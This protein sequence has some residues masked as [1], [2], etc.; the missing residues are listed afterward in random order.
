M[1]T[2]IKNGHVIDINLKINEI[3]DIYINDG[4]VE[5]IGK[6]NFDKSDNTD[7]SGAEVID[8]K[9]MYVVPG[10]IDAHCHLRDPGFE[11]KE[12]IESG[13]RSA[14]KGGFTSVA[15][16]PNTNP[17]IDN[18]SVVSYVKN[19]SEKE[20][21]VN[22]FPIGAISKGCKGEELAEIG[23]LKFA[24]AVAISD[25]GKPVN[26]AGLMK[27]ALM[28]SSMFDIRVISH[29]EELSLAEDGVMNEGYNSTILGLKG[30]PAAAEETMIA[31]DLILS[32]Y[33]SVP[34]HIA[35]VS[36][37]LGI[38]LIR[39]AKK[40]GV[41]V[42]CE[43]C[44][45]YFSLTD[46]ACLEFN[47]LAKVNPP[48]RRDSDVE[49]VIEGLS[50]GTIDIIATDHAPHHND[51]KKIEFGYAAN[52]MV[53]FETALSLTL[54][55]LYFTGKLSMEQII[56]KMTVNPAKI[57]NIPK[58]DIAVGKPC[59][60]TIFNPDEEYEIN[61]AEFESKGKNSPFDGY[62]VKGRVKYTIVNGNIVV[63]DGVVM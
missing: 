15:C 56:E 48:L 49:A 61:I 11:Y 21:Y 18:E 38:D 45:H 43:T 63:R 60:I 31:R 55:N 39:N 13:T 35:H 25:D 5:A 3:T 34:V 57:L 4:I 24:G 40:R 37:K 54:T 8:A 42:T 23:E 53:G 22:V 10:L 6:E 14:A 46:D 41:K 27:K 44:P 9:G 7:I 62:K 29:C 59:D 20:G 52:G 36:T 51:E 17:V 30:I 12:D 16:M 1:R 26:S 50:D 33:T 32:E 58:G 2:I 28:Y 19:K 47:T